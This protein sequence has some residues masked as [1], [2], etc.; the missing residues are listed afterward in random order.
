MYDVTFTDSL[1]GFI[2]GENGWVWRTNDGGNTW[3]PQQWGIESLRDIFMVNS[4]VGFIAGDNKT[5]LRTTNGGGFFGRMEMPAIMIDEVEDFRAIY[6]FSQNDAW[7]LGHQRGTILRLQGQAWEYIGWTGYPYTGLAMPAPDQGWA[8]TEEGYIYHYNGTRWSESA[9]KLVS[10]PLRAIDMDSPTEGWAAGDGGVVVRYANGQWTQ[11]LIS[12]AFSG[13]GITG[14]YVRAADDVWA[15]AT[16]GTD[17]RADGAI[18]RYHDGRW[19][20]VTYTYAGQLN[21]VWVNDALTSGWAVG[22]NGF[23]MRY[24]IPSE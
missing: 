6:A 14:L 23:V 4:Q 2:V 12:G 19:E 10:T 18:Y 17:E 11:S 1:R 21:A 9:S 24:V 22:N 5:I 3:T 20:R 13:G 16:I 15:T 7:A 8:I